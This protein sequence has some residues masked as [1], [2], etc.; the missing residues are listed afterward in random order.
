MVTI[1]VTGCELQDEPEMFGQV[2]SQVANGTGI[3][4]VAP[5]RTRAVTLGTA[6]KATLQ[7][8]QAMR[9]T[10][11]PGDIE[12]TDAI[13]VGGETEVLPPEEAPRDPMGPKDPPT[14]MARVRT[15]KM[16]AITKQSLTRSSVQL[17][18]PPTEWMGESEAC[19]QK[20]MP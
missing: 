20:S 8:T 10:G 18:P 16:M 17:T 3:K 9:V 2:N 11:E 19:S 5:T 13:L 6:P 14:T 15:M 1:L 12:V 4:E 7:I